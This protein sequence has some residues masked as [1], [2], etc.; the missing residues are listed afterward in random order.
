VIGIAHDSV[1]SLRMRLA[2]AIA[3]GAE[4]ILTAAGSHHGEHDIV[5][6]LLVGEG[7]LGF[8]QVAMEPDRPLLFGLLAGIPVIGLPGDPAEALVCAELF[9]R[10]AVLRLTGRDDLARP[11]VH[12]TLDAP[13]ACHPHRH[14]VRGTVRQGGAG[15]SVQLGPELGLTA[16]LVEANALVVIPPGEGILP[17]GSPVEVLLI[18]TL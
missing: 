3:H 2:E 9:A 17:A 13:V 15:F 1:D 12:A 7:Q 5:R 8:W 6:E 4:L 18:E 14:Y 11:M 10:P 16:A